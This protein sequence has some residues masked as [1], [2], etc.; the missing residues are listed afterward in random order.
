MIALWFGRSRVPAYGSSGEKLR[1]YRNRAS[2]RAERIMSYSM[3]MR[4]RVP[5]RRTP[6]L[7]RARADEDPALAD[8][9]GYLH[10]GERETVG[11]RS[12]KLTRSITHGAR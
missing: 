1:M 9:S 4:N 10:A 3:S 6:A 12:M 11:A 7:D 5:P 2:T 8:A